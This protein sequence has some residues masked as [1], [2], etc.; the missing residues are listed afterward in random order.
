MK[1]NL[2]SNRHIGPEMDV[3]DPDHTWFYFINPNEIFL[4][5]DGVQ[6]KAICKDSKQ[7]DINYTGLPEIKLDMLNPSVQN[8]LHDTTKQTFPHAILQ[9]TSA[10]VVAENFHKPGKVLSLV[11]GPLVGRKIS[12]GEDALGRW[13]YRNN[14][15]ITVMSVY[16]VY[17]N[18]KKSGTTAYHQQQSMLKQQNSPMS[19]P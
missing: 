7:Q 11:Q 9:S 1:A 14:M 4:K 2:E 8:I 10:P 18:N 15:V 6:F 16:Q 12:S 17:Q 3:K 5:Y 13:T 19:N